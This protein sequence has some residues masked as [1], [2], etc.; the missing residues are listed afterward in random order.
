MIGFDVKEE[1]IITKREEGEFVKGFA[2]ID[3]DH[4]TACMYVWIHI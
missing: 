1:C 3:L 4:M 2:T